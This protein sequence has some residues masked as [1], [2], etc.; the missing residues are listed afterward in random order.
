MTMSHDH[1]TR[2]PTGERVVALSDDSN[3]SCRFCGKQAAWERIGS[4]SR[5][6]FCGISEC[7]VKAL[8]E[9]QGRI[10]IL[11]PLELDEIL[12]K[13]CGL[14]PLAR[15]IINAGEDFGRA[16]HETPEERRLRRARKL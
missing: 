13:V 1:P 16:T 5:F 8:P 12:D 14:S 7:R 15:R 11:G 10:P 2:L 6:C 3:E 9:T 4:G